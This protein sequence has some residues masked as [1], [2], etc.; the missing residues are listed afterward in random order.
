MRRV[1]NNFILN[2]YAEIIA[3]KLTELR[4]F[5]IVSFQRSFPKAIDAFFFNY[6]FLFMLL[7]LSQFSP[8]PPPPNHILPQAIP[9]P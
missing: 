5:F 4:D 1:W 9:K 8:C 3:R 2:D 7:E 6:I